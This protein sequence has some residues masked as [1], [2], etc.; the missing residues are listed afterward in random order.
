MILKRMTQHDKQSGFSTVELLFIVGVAGWFVTH[1]KHSF[2]K[3]PHLINGS[4]ST[5]SPYRQAMA[6][7]DHATAFWPSV[8]TIFKSNHELAK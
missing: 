5:V 2:L 4:I 8:A 7:A 6:N 1:H 3:Q